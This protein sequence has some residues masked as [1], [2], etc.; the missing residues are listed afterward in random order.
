MRFEMRCNVLGAWLFK[1]KHTQVTNMC[2]R[3]LQFSAAKL[4]EFVKLQGHCSNDNKL[5]IRMLGINEENFSR[6]GKALALSFSD[7]SSHYE[8]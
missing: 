8:N 4:R 2:R 6:V 3:V 1:G 5:I 7:K